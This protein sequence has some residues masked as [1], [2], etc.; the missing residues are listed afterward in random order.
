ME[1]RI[2]EPDRE[3]LSLCSAPFYRFTGLEVGK[4]RIDAHIAIHKSI[5][6]SSVFRGRLIVDD[7]L[8]NLG[9]A[10]ALGVAQL[11]ECAV[12]S[13]VGHEAY[14]LTSCE[15]QAGCRAG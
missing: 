11:G 7:D 12:V 5:C 8:D 13:V 14:L 10:G 9:G 4:I 15:S 1:F 2:L 3:L 6:I